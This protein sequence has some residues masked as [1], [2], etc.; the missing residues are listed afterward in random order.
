MAKSKINKC[1]KTK[2]P[3]F[4]DIVFFYSMNTGHN[5]EKSEEGGVDFG[6]PKA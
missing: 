4:E 3:L 2:R 1:K 6:Y 5:S